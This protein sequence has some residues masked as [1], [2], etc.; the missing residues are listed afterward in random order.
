[1]Y[2]KPWFDPFM[3]YIIFSV[4]R[5]RGFLFI[6]HCHNTLFIANM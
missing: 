4:I 1:M 2:K 5:Q 3:L 6:G